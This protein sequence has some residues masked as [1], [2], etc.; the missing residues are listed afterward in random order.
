MKY[1][2]YEGISSLTVCSSPLVI[3]TG[4]Q[5]FVGSERESIEGERTYYRPIANEYTTLY[6][7]V[8]EFDVPMIRCQG[9]ISYEEQRVIETWLT[10]P[11][12]S[13]VMTIKDT[14]DSSYNIKY[15]GKVI[16]TEWYPYPDGFYG[17]SF[18]FRCTTPYPFV[19]KH[20]DHTSTSAERTLLT[21]LSDS[22]EL[23]DYIYPVLTLQSTSSGSSQHTIKIINRTDDGKS[24]SIYINA[25]A[26]IIMDCRNLRITSDDGTLVDYRNISWDNIENVYWI[27]V[28]AGRNQW[29]CEGDFHIDIDFESPIKKVGGW[30]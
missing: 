1:F 18:T 8:L 26:T 5:T 19:S 9:F 4:N 6:S 16:K 11:R 10:S 29:V 23:E 21:F 3:A 13:R 12:L 28:I 14:E 27:R 22:D 30:V 24:F 15:R 2:V 25:G 20:F 7:D 17:F